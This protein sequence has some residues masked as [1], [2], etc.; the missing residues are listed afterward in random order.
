MAATSAGMLGTSAGDFENLLNVLLAVNEQST[1]LR[2]DLKDD[3]TTSVSKLREAYN[4]L[5]S[6]IAAKDILIKDLEREISQAK[7]R[8]PVES[9]VNRRM[10]YSEVVT[11]QQQR[12]VETK[13]F[14]VIVK[15]KKNQTAEYIKTYIKSKVSPAEMKVGVSSLKSLKNGNIL[16]QTG[17]KSD[18]DSICNNINE[19]CGDEV[20]ANGTKLWNPRLIIYNIPKDMEMDVVKDAILEQNSE[21]NLQES[22]ITPKFIFKDRK[23]NS[24]L[25]IEVNPETRKKL[26][27]KK[28]KVGWHMCGHDDYIKINRCYKCNK[29]NHRANE[30][31]GVLACPLCAGNHSLREC[32]AQRDQYR[33]INCINFNKFNTKE[34][35]HEQHSALDKNCSHY[36]MQVKK[37]MEHIN[38]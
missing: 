16:I 17:N 34:P 3:I 38:Y 10:L 6:Q 14:N 31:K 21:L 19:K 26:Q 33:C 37:Y 23:E 22:D 4:D 15:A 32:T 36:K 9:S 25:I 1:K 35:A 27:E 29:Y 7:N 8:T 5:I 28:L 18:M 24:N 12:Q 11:V 13:K 30:C 20:V 2:K